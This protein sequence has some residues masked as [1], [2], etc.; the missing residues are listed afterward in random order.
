MCGIAGIVCR[1]AE[2]PVAEERLLRMAAAI[3]HRGPDGFGLAL[4]PGAGLVSSRLAIIDLA[5]GWQPIE[6]R[7]GGAVLVYNGEVYNHAELRAELESRG[8]RFATASDTEVVLRLLERDGLGALERLNGQFALAWWNPQ[9]RRLV[10]V[11]DRFGVRP[12][13]YALLDDGTLVFGSEAKALFASGLVEAAPDLEGIDDVFTLW[14]PRP[15]RTVF[16]GVRQLPPG[17]VLVW[18]AGR[19]VDERVWWTP[20]PWEAPDTGSDIEELLRDSVR[21]RLQADVPVGAYLSGGLDSSLIS[22][23]AQDRTGGHLRTFSI[24]FTDPRYDERGYQEVVAEALQTAHHVVEASSADIADAFPEVV[25]HA[26]VPLVRTAPVPLYLLAREVRNQ[27]I[28]V[29]I[30]GEGADELFWG[31]DLFKEV[32]LRELHARDPERAGELLDR[33]YPYLD[34]SGGRRGPAWRRFLLGTGSADDPIASHITRAEATATVKSFY[35]ADV[36]SE[37][38]ARDPLGRLRDELP[39][40]FAGLGPLERASWLEVATLLEPYLLAAQGDRV[41]MAHGVEGR[42]PFLDH[43]VYAHAVHL[44]A[45]RKLAGLRDKVE[46]RELAKRVLPAPIA[47]RP[48][49]PYRA[50]EVEPFFA[51]D[52][53]DWVEHLVEPAALAASNMWDERRVSRLLERCRA[54]RATGMRE[55]MALVGVLST[56]LWHQSFCAVGPDTYPAETMEPRIRID[57]TAERAVEAVT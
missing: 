56:Q 6:A 57:R 45:E 34:P 41:A 40:G 38:A 10:L 35:N 47:E 4:D 25:R 5:G 37:L 27:G 7:P 49:Q 22:S 43:R 53:P 14:G 8:E 21:L 54:G 24:T 31:Y 11:R 30:T 39:S 33:L 52:A 26:E 9:T 15:P 12:L 51:P 19:I 46:L 36:A 20:A 2:Q 32:A 28:T 3:R 29:V 13:H 48:K 44:G 16:R 18:E 55:S 23:L 1:Q 50:P 42:Y 17:S